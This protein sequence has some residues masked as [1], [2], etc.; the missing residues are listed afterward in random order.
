[1]NPLRGPV[2]FFV[3]LISLSGSPAIQAAGNAEIP[4]SMAAIGDSITAGAVA[5]FTT[6]SWI[7]PNE[8]LGLIYRLFAVKIKNS[9]EPAQRKDLSWSTGINRQRWVDSHYALLSYLAYREGKHVEAYNAAVSQDDSRDLFDQLGNVMHWS[10]TTQNQA[11]PDYVTILIGANDLCQKNGVPPTP[12]EVYRD[13]L[14]KVIHEIL[15]RNKKSKVMLV[16]LPD[17]N[18]VYDFAKER[19]LSRIKKFQSCS[20][21]WRSANVCPSVLSDL[22]P[23]ERQ[24]SRGVNMEYNRVLRETTARFNSGKG[25]YGRDR[26][27]LSRG[28]FNIDLNFEKMAIDCFHP[29]HRGQTDISINSFYQSWWAPQ[30][31]KAAANYPSWVELVRQK[32]LR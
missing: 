18:R 6:D 11:M 21:L 27:R 32:K 17:I 24:K 4:E 15:V 1:M 30:F 2:L 3:L 23:A 31:H 9:V 16:E 26:V 20:V 22:T 7:H 25:G 13:R 14:T 12:V 28:F 19:R 10:L 29:N 8:L 5:Q